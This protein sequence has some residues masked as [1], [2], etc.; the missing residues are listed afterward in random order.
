[1]AAGKNVNMLV[2]KVCAMGKNTVRR[3]RQPLTST[4]SEKYF[5][6]CALTGA[7]A[8]FSTGARVLNPRYT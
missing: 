4:C 1:M 7:D 3:T 6:L 5:V 2:R 8:V